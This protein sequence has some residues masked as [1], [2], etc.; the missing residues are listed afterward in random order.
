MLPTRG[1]A[2]PDRGLHMAAAGAGVGS[3]GAQPV[4][5]GG[6][7]AAGCGQAKTLPGPPTRQ[8]ARAPGDAVRCVPPLAVPLLCACGT[9]C[10]SLPTGQGVS[11]WDH[12]HL[13]TTER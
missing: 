1:R 9:S 8:P 7:V 6:G 2:L 5:G 3:A 11:A 10:L 4:R 13:L 12:A